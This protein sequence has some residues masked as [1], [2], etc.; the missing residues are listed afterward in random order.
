ML[1]RRMEKRREQYFLGNAMR[2]GNDMIF[3]SSMKMIKRLPW[4]ADRFD[5][6]DK[7]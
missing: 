7:I 2:A 5:G 3:A 6:L 4:P 1:V